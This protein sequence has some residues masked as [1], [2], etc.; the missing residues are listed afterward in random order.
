M[1][2]AGRRAPAAAK[3][4][5][6]RSSRTGAVRASG[7]WW[8]LRAA[9]PVKIAPEPPTERVSGPMCPQPVPAGAGALRTEDR[10]GRSR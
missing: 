9:P 5:K 4:V 6:G 3:A 10:S 1:I 7:G 2:A 8:K